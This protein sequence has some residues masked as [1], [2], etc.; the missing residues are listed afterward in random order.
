MNWHLYE[1]YKWKVKDI[2]T[3]IYIYSFVSLSKYISISDTFNSCWLGL[4]SLA[5]ID[6]LLLM[7]SKGN[8]GMKDTYPEKVMCKIQVMFR[9]M[10]SYIVF[11]L[12]P[13][14]MIWLLW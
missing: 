10:T 9:T 6:Q 8:L 11:V 13:M 14:E 7:L 2:S 5:L 4:G 3:E 12:K 1:R